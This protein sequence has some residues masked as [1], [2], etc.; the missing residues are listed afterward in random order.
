MNFSRTY[1]V[2]RVASI[3]GFRKQDVAIILDALVEV[4]VDI[5]KKMVPGDILIIRKLGVFKAKLKKPQVIMMANPV[6]SPWYKTISFKLSVG[7]KADFAL[8]EDAAKLYLEIQKSLMQ[9]QPSDLSQ[10]QQNESQ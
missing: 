3:T 1:L 9:N 8:T 2:S 4:M 5:F 6:F 7:L 10:S